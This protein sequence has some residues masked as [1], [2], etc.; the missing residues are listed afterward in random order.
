MLPSVHLSLPRRILVS[1]R[2]IATSNPGA[3]LKKQLNSSLILAYLLWRVHLLEVD[4]KAQNSEARFSMSWM[5]ISTSSIPSRISNTVIYPLHAGPCSPLRAS[6][7]FRSWG[8]PL[9]RGECG[10]SIHPHLLGRS[11]A[12][13]SLSL[14]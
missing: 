10:L 13:W 9:S 12:K 1:S 6:A 2:L 11:A 7:T 8:K 3:L 5:S 4:M 14:C